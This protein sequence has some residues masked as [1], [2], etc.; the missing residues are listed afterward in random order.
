MKCLR[1]IMM[2]EEN[3][4]GWP[5]T[6]LSI[7]SQDYHGAPYQTLD[8]HAITPQPRPLAPSSP[9][10]FHRETP[11]GVISRDDICRKW[12]PNRENDRHF[13]I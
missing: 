5:A 11:P 1:E 2:F 12:L 13:V 4:I 9:A 8:L 10:F 6:F 7:S 3:Q